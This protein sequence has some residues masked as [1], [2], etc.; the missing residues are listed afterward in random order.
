[1]PAIKNPHY[2]W[3]IFSIATM[4]S[5]IRHFKHATGC[6]TVEAL[7]AA[8]LHPAQLLTIQHLKGTLDYGTEG[9]FVLLDDDLNVKQTFI[10]GEKVWDNERENNKGN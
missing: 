8:T 9:D 2:L 7:E 5:C 10:A 1:M 3:F 6:T 4:D